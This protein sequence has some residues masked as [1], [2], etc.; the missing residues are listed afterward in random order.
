MSILSCDFFFE[1]KK[2]LK[3]FYGQSFQ[4]P[5][6][7]RMTDF[8]YVEIGGNKRTDKLDSIPALYF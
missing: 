3:I 7:N 4:D 1:Y 8:N 5:D 6:I 2:I